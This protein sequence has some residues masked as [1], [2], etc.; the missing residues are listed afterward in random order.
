MKFVILVLMCLI[1]TTANAVPNVST[2]QTNFLAKVDT[3]CTALVA[4]TGFDIYNQ[5]NGL[6]DTYYDAQAVA[7]NANELNPLVKWI[8]CANA[9][10]RIYVTDYVLLNNGFIPGYWNF[11]DGARMEWQRTADIPSRNAVIALAT[12]AAFA[13]DTTPENMSLQNYVRETALAILSYLNAEEVGQPR[14]AR[15]ATLVDAALSHIDKLEAGQINAVKPFMFGL[16]AYALMR[17][18]EKTGDSRIVPALVRLAAALAPYYDTASDSFFYCTEVAGGSCDD[19]FHT[20]AVDLNMLIAPLYG[21]LW[22][23]TANPAYAVTGDE[24]FNAGLTAF[25]AGGKQT[26]QNFWLSPRYLKDR[27]FYP[28]QAAP[29]PVPVATPGAPTPTPTPAPTATPGAIPTP[30]PGDTCT[31]NIPPTNPSHLCANKLL[32]RIW[33]K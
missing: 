17:V 32:W 3:N 13:R 4:A 18:Y 33:K 24:I 7:L 11:T 31:G 6:G 22:K 8:T 29:T 25:I 5:P 10:K 21:F 15:L 12:N 2:W 14:R 1:A 26:N 28:G 20:P 19:P 16:N 23:Q 9:A 30:A 27:G